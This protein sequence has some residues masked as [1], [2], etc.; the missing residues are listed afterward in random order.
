MQRIG[1][2]G[3][4]LLGSAVASRLLDHG[5]NVIGFDTRPEPLAVLADRGLSAA[6]SVAEVAAEAEAILT[7]LP[8]LDAVEA[9][10]CGADGL[11]ETARSGTVIMQMSTISPELTQRLCT[12]VEARHLHFLD[13]PISGTSA[14]VARGDCTIF[15]GGGLE[16][17]QRCDALFAAIGRRAVH[18]GEVGT[19]SLAKLATNLLVALNTAALA[20]AMVLA[21]KGGIDPALMLDTLMDSAANSRML[22]IR[23]PLMVAGDYPPQMKL[24]LFLKDIR[25]MLEAGDQLDVAL[26]L[27]QTARRLFAATADAHAGAGEQDLA[28][29][30]KEL[31]RLAGM[32]RPSR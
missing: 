5:F 3:V 16:Q 8:S 30:I 12:Q 22:E 10:V 13:T 11:T 28:V 7:I 19:A 26:P 14:M 15:V 1:I 27:T 29:V 24:E 18:L 6:T 20:E 9:V 32:H 25:L 21:A 23:G 17:K 31:E 2:I 4:G